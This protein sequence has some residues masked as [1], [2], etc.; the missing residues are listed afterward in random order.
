MT[1]DPF[2]AVNDEPQNA[3]AETT[4]T[5]EPTPKENRPMAVSDQS[6]LTLTLKGGAGFDSPWIVIHADGPGEAL[7][8]LNDES[9]K[10]LMEVSQNAAKHFV[11]KNQI[12]AAPAQAN[13]G[14][15]AGATQ[16]PNGE[17]PPPGYVFKSGFSN[18]TNKPWKAFMPIDKNSGLEV[19]WLR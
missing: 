1:I 9:L 8:I 5:P 4:P 17:T 7:N 6:K 2:A 19:K 12:G 3:P 18:K 11:S 10:S 13:N 15:P 16:A 14:Q